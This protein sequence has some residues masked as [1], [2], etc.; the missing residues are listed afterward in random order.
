MDRSALIHKALT[1]K[2]NKAEIAELNAWLSSDP[3]HAEEFNVVK[4][5]YERSL[6]IEERIIERDD[7]FYNALRNIQNRIKALK[8]GK[9]K[10]KRYKIAGA[11]VLLSG[12]VIV[13]SIYIFNSN[14]ASKSHDEPVQKTL[15]DNLQFENA[16]LESIC[17]ILENKYQVILKVK[18]EQLLLCKFS[19]TFHRGIAIEDILHIFSQSGGFNYTVVDA[20]TY[21]LYGRGCS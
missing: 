10:A 20:Q 13:A 5:L 8:H 18:S 19:G 15:S 9:K 2:A 3:S 7:K 11:A 16:T 21:E 17:E 6:N 14:T 1:T 12:M 4:L